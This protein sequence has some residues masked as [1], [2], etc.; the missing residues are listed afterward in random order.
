MSTSS[1]GEYHR[2]K[3]PNRA[4]VLVKLS[5]HNII[6]EVVSDI[7]QNDIPMSQTVD[8]NLRQLFAPFSI[9]LCPSTQEQHTTL[10][11]E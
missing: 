1:M 9:H 4:D 11:T 3:N 6:K 7:F 8:R 2:L 5:S 10:R